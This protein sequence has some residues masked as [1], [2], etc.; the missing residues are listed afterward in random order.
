M[1]DIIYN[2]NQID[3]YQ[4]NNFYNNVD[5]NHKNG[6]MQNLNNNVYINNLFE[7]VIYYI[8]ENDM[9]NINNYNIDDIN[10]LN[11]IFNNNLMDQDNVMEVQEEIEIIPAPYQ[12]S[13]LTEETICSICLENIEIDTECI[14]TECNH[15]FHGQCFQ[16]WITDHNTCPNCRHEF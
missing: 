14:V 4:V 12:I 5:E 10:I 2:N 3:Y 7:A 15:V 8:K 16:P 1:V 6:I 11:F 9:F 13:T